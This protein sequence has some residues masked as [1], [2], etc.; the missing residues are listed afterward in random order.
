M[1][2][3]SNSYLLSNI[4]RTPKFNGYGKACAYKRFS[5]LKTLSFHSVLDI[6]SGACLLQ[7]WFQKN[8]INVDYEAV[9]I[10]S[11][12]LSLCNCPRYLNVPEHRKYD[13]VC[14]FGT[15]TY[16]IDNDD[17]KNKKILFDLLKK[18]TLISS[19]YILFTVFKEDISKKYKNSIPQNLFVYFSIEE[20]NNILR[21][22]GIINFKIIENNEL[23]DQEYFVI[24]DLKRTK[25]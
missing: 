9:D 10:R 23:D 24:C 16:N 22:L 6:G 21:E 4:Y 8:N 14:L 18:S 20:I 1:H 17:K 5:V 19:K 11:D 2:H 12:A 3:N 7:Q 25:I 15:V 13:L